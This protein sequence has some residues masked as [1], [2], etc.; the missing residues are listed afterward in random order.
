M[1][2][3]WEHEDSGDVKEEIV[4][5]ALISYANDTDHWR[6]DIPWKRLTRSESKKKNEKA[7]EQ[8]L[9]S[10]PKESSFKALLKGVVQYAKE[11]IFGKP[12]K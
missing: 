1:D 7:I 11:E 8:H 5:K 2:G 10:L 6:E 3:L 9:E 12:L 4:I